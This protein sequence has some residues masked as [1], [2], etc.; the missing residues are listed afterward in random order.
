MS[1]TGFVILYS[2]IMFSLAFHILDLNVLNIRRFLFI[3]AILSKKK[4]I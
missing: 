3:L 4:K 2:Q 1:F